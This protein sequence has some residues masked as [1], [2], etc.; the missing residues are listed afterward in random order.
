V[1]PPEPLHLGRD[2]AALA[3]VLSTALA[4]QLLIF[5]RWASLLDEAAIVHIADQINHGGVPYRDAVHVAFPGVFYLTAALFRLAGPSIVAGRVL[6]MGVFTLFVV[7]VYLLA[8]TVAGRAAATGAALLAVAY[9]MWAFPHWHMLSYTPLAILLLTT[10]V[11]LL[12]CDNRRPHGMWPVLAGLAVGLGI[13]FKQDCSAVVF[14]CL[15]LFLLLS[16]R[17]DTGAWAPALRRTAVYGVAAA[18]PPAAAIVAFARLGL[19]GEMLWQTI[20]FPLI[21]QPVWAPSLGAETH[22]YTAFPPLW[23]PHE[24]SLAIRKTGFFSYFPSLALDLYW[25]EIWQHPLFVRSPLPEIFVRVAYLL[26]FLLLVILALSDGLAAHARYRRGLTAVPVHARQLRLLLVFGVGLMLSF[27]RPRDWVHLMILYPAT[28]ILL[29]AGAELVAGSGPGLRRQIVRA[30]GAAAVAGALVAAFA[31]AV[32][33][34]RFYDV[35]LANPRAGVRVNED[36]AAA[37]NALLPALAVAEGERP[38]PLGALP[39]NPALNF[40]TGR[41]LATRFLTVL[42]LE[43]FPDRQEQILADVERD[44]STD[45]VYSLQHLSSI[46]RPQRYAP[47]LLA[48]LIDRYELGAGPG[49][50]FNGSRM[51]GL[52]F[53]RLLPRTPRAELVVYDFAAHLADAAVVEVGGAEAPHATPAIDDARVRVDMWPF[54]RPVITVWAG[55]APAATRLAY[56]VTVPPGTRLRFGVAMDPDEWTHFLPTELHFAVRLDDRIVFEQRLDPRRRFED[57]RWVWAD[58]PVP[59]GPHAIA[60]DVSAE[61]AYGQELNLAGWARPRLAADLPLTSPSS[62]DAGS[63]FSTAR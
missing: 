5:D 3:L 59:D 58:L 17:R 57:R 35:P 38:P 25:K 14:L 61:N 39:Y 23:P 63:L 21:A 54:E 32:A 40:L 12:A 20:G 56:T 19:A 55:V 28:L 43:E 13:V 48:G 10:A 51:D 31:L 22:H 1:K 41:P 2:G 8:R 15:G 53:V 18:L 49:M 36:A 26:P 37:L 42:P 33:A 7:L 29:A 27:N 30:A 4:L 62:Q 24:P 44:P 47:R 34:R 52:L 45:L 60:F 50:V 6:M 46:T 16:A 11:A 9:R